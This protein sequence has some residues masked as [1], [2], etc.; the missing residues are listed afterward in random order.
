MLLR[1][2]PTRASRIEPFGSRPL[3]RVADHVSLAAMENRRRI[4]LRPWIAGV[5]AYAVVLQ[6]FLAGLVHQAY[7]GPSLD[8]FAICYGNGESGGQSLPGKLPTHQLPCVLCVCSAAGVAGILPAA[9]TAPASIGLSAAFLAAPGTPA[10]FA[11]R[12]TP[13]LSQGPPARA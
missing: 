12:R 13:K 10:V 2:R 11:A 4:A 6:L 1:A 7:A 5:A 3:F 8:P 9:A